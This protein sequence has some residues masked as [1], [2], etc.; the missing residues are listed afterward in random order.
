MRTAE[1]Y[2]LAVVSGVAAAELLSFGV[3]AAVQWFWSYIDRCNVKELEGE[4]QILNTLGRWGMRPF[5]MPSGKT[6]KIYK[7]EN[8]K[9]GRTVA[10][11]VLS[12]DHSNIDSFRLPINNS[13]KQE[14]RNNQDMLYD[15]DWSSN[16]SSLYTFIYG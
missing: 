9:R 6:S 7:A 5:V 2:A 14:T 4:F 3:E 13:Y 10:L 1:K 15:C 8:R 16:A 12:S 11:K